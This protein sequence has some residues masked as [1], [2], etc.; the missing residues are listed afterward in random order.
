MRRSGPEWP[1][2]IID[3]LL[4]RMTALFLRAWV[5]IRTEQRTLLVVAGTANRPRSSGGEMIE[6]RTSSEGTR[7]RSRRSGPRQEADLLRD[8]SWRLFGAAER[9]YRSAAGFAPAHAGTESS[10]EIRP[11]TGRLMP[12]TRQCNETDN[13]IAHIPAATRRPSRQGSTTGGT[14]CRRGP[15]CTER[16][17]TEPAPELRRDVFA[18]RRL[19]QRSVFMATSTG[20]PVRPFVPL[21]DR[22]RWTSVEFPAT[23]KE[24][25][26]VST[27]SRD[28][29][30]RK[31]A[32]PCHMKFATVTAPQKRTPRLRRRPVRL[33]RQLSRER[34]GSRRTVEAVHARETCPQADRS[35]TPEP[36][37][38][39][40]E[41][42]CH[43]VLTHSAN[44]SAERVV[45]LP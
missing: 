20:P 15:Q 12:A 7:R 43:P 11:E 4:V 44:W 35:R 24:H 36:A 21:Q 34:D 42:L 13:R 28:A 19:D 9:Q 38:P 22:S 40:G 1:P 23:G 6:G 30:T 10:V 41:K 5:R 27:P 8:P 45:T 33:S 32:S 26:C 29:L 31:G 25:G 14:A 39:H 2:C 37:R 16:R 17:T 18:G 3:P